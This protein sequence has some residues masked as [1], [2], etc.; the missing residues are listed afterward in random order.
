MLWLSQS[1]SMLNL[2]LQSQPGAPHKGEGGLSRLC[3]NGSSAVWPER[4]V[5]GA[6]SHW[7]PE[8]GGNS[9]S[10]FSSTQ[11]NRNLRTSLPY[12]FLPFP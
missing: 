3:L 12:G 10:F 2:Q 5:V 9:V 1:Y 4:V 8:I 7:A 6:T 11:G